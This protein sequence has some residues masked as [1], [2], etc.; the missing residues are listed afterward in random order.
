MSSKLITETTK[1]FQWIPAKA[2]QKVHPS[3]DLILY[4][5]FSITYHMRTCVQYCTVCCTVYIMQNMFL[6]C[7]AE[8]Y[9]WVALRWQSRPYQHCRNTNSWD[10]LLYLQL[11]Q[12]SLDKFRNIFLCFGYIVT[13]FTLGVQDSWGASLLVFINN[14][15]PVPFWSCSYLFKPLPWNVPLPF[16]SITFMQSSFKLQQI[17]L[18]CNI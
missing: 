10:H 4:K 12:W 14:F 1:R 18:D 17:Q 7:A 9:L 5:S 11:L 8:E 3:V 16:S 6:C 15:F 13:T 2:P